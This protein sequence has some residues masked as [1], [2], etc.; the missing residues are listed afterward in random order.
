MSHWNHRIVKQGSQYSI[1]E[2]YYNKGDVEFAWQEKPLAPVAYEDED[3]ENPIESLK[4]QLEQ[5]LKALEHPVFEVFD[6][7]EV[8][9]VVETII[10]HDPIEFEIDT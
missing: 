9:S 4:W 7:S 2:V 3:H 6:D 5:M 8:N 10:D 1:R